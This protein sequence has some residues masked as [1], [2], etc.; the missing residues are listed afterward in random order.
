LPP[1]GNCA[2]PVQTPTDK[3]SVKANSLTRIEEKQNRIASLLEGNKRGKERAAARGRR[4]SAAAGE[5]KEVATSLQIA[6]CA[7]LGSS[8]PQ[9]GAAVGPVGSVGGEQ[10]ARWWEE[11][12]RRPPSSGSQALPSSLP[13]ARRPSSLSSRSRPVTGGRIFCGGGAAWRAGAASSTMAWSAGGR[14]L[15]V[16]GLVGGRSLLGGGLVGGRARPRQ[17]RRRRRG[18]G[19]RERDWIF[20]CLHRLHCSCWRPCI[21]LRLGCY[22]TRCKMAFAFPI[23]HCIVGL[24]LRAQKC[25]AYYMVALLLLL[26]TCNARPSTAAARGDSTARGG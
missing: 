20:F 24:S 8:S 11:H 26:P 10:P 22:C 9:R 7:R 12:H 17:V 6:E 21:L 16:G 5:K 2:R 3:A 1:A 25:N 15:D 13:P 23:L 14:G 18:G 19:R 4:R